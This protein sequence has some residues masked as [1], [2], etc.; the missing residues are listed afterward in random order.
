VNRKLFISTL[1]TLSAV[2]CGDPLKDAQRIEELRVLGARIAIDDAPD[3]ATPEA[4]ESASVEWLLADPSGLP[5]TAVWHMSVCVAE[6]TT[7]DVPYCRDAPL[8]SAEQSE[9]SDATP[10]IAFTVPDADTLG[11]AKKLAVLAIFCDAGTVEVGDDFEGTTC[12]GAATIQK[13]S[14]EIFLDDGENSNENPKLDGATLAFDDDPWP[15]DGSSVDC[16][17]EATPRLPA[18]GKEHPVKLTLA[19]EAREKKAPELG[20]VR[21]ESLQISHFSTLGEFDRRFSDVSPDDKN[22]T[23]EVPW[24]A[25]GKL[26]SPTPASFYFVVRD[27]RGG[28]SWLTRSVC[29]DP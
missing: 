24:K 5:A 26:T 9:P 28:V 8:G 25:P 22:L 4:G 3:R 2:A 14:F 6:P 18:D 29:I 11:D 16:S 10:S 27:D 1:A 13:A 17:D 7:F 21:S 20:T 15:A 12:S 23:I 19:A